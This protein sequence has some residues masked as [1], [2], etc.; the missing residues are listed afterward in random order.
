MLPVPNMSAKGTDLQIEVFL[1]I[2][3]GLADV[4][5]IGLARVPHM[6]S[7]GAH[8]LVSPETERNSVKCTSVCRGLGDSAGSSQKQPVKGCSAYWKCSGVISPGQSVSV[9]G[10]AGRLHSVTF[11]K[12]GHRGRGLRFSSSLL[13][14]QFEQPVP[15]GSWTSWHVW[16]G[17]FASSWGLRGKVSGKTNGI[18]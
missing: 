8:R 6:L 12:P 15:Q 7:G 11:T 14:T 3:F 1:K 13:W 9:G 4:W 5:L 16:A 2:L 18:E 10:R 17:A